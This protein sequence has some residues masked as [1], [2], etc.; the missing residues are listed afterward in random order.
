MPHATTRNYLI[1]TAPQRIELLGDRIKRPE[2]A[3]HVIEFPGGAIELSRT[4]EG[5]Y[6]AHIIVNRDFAL[7]EDIE[8]MEAAYG[9]IVDSRIDY[10]FPADPN[11]VDIPNSQQVRQ[12]AI[13]IRPQLDKK[14][15]SLP[16]L[17]GSR[18]LPLFN[19]PISPR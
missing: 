17:P 11:T 10:E 19:T 4:S 3:T 9:Q 5:F 8:G 7:P 14:V 1:D 15:P 12:I 2:P 13:L 16:L 18:P 6:W